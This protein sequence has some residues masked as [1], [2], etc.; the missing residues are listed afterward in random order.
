MIKTSRD[1][2]RETIALGMTQKEVAERIGATQS[3]V[4]KLIRGGISDI[5]YATGK[6]LEALHQERMAAAKLINAQSQPQ[7]HSHPATNSTP[8]D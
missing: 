8:A 7:P 1:L 2:A 4:S 3:T 6:H 5:S